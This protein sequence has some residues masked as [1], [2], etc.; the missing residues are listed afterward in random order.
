M[1]NSQTVTEETLFGVVRYVLETND[2]FAIKICAPNISSVTPIQQTPLLKKLQ[3][4]KQGGEIYVHEESVHL[5]HSLQ[6]SQG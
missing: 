5:K 2:E 4:M 6:Q 1:Q 3:L